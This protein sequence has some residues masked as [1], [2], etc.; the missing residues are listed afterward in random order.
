MKDRKEILSGILREQVGEVVTRSP[1]P[2]ML[3]LAPVIRK[4][5]DGV[6]IFDYTI[7]PEMVNPAGSLHGG[8]IAAIM[9]DLIG[10]TIISLGKSVFYLTI[11]NVIDYFAAAR[12]GDVVQGRTKIIKLG[13]QIITVEFELW[14]PIKN[15]LLARGS[16]NLMRTELP[17]SEEGKLA[18]V[19]Q[20]V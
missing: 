5:E 20:V 9:D 16:S 19:A 12:L 8:I 14:L 2:L 11:N 4:V 10:A 1:S 7:R 15:R 13:R 3:W 17:M 18:T 6:L